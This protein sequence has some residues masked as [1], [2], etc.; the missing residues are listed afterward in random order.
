MRLLLFTFLLSALSFSQDR[1]GISY[2]ALI[3]NPNVE[4][5]P[6]QDNDHSPLTNTD[7]C[8]QFHI[9]NSSG[10]YEYSESQSVTTDA[11][12]MVNLVIGTGLPIGAI[13]WDAV[14]WSAEAKSLK[15]DLDITG[16]CTSF[17][18][19]S[20]QQ[21]TSVPF[22]LYSPSSNVPGPKGDPGD[23]GADGDSA[24]QVWLDE[25]NTGTEQ[26][27]LDA[28]KGTDGTPGA[29]GDSAYQVWLD[30]GNTGTEQEFLESLKG[31]DGSP[32][33]GTEGK[34]AYDIWIELGNT[35]TE[36]DF[37]D[38]LVGPQGE[39]GQDGAG[40]SG[41]G[42][43]NAINTNETSLNLYGSS[44]GYNRFKNFWNT[45]ESYSSNFYTTTSGNEINIY[46]YDLNKIGKSINIDNVIFPTGFNKFNLSSFGGVSAINSDGTT[47]VSGFRTNDDKSYYA[48]IELVNS[49]WVVKS[50]IERPSVN[51][52][53]FN[54]DL[55]K[56]ITV[57]S[58][59]NQYYL[60]SHEIDL[61]NSTLTLID[62]YN[63]PVTNTYQFY[64]NDDFNN[65]V[66]TGF[67]NSRLNMQLINISSLGIFSKK[68]DFSTPHSF[69]N[70]YD[71]Y[72]PQ[73][74]S[75]SMNSD[76]TVL[77]VIISCITKHGGLNSQST[78][79][80]MKI[81]SVETNTL[82]NKISKK[83][84]SNAYSSPFQSP[85][86][87]LNELG[88]RI[89]LGSSN[90]TFGVNNVL[91]NVY[92]IS[93]DELNIIGGSSFIP[94]PASDSNYTNTLRFYNPGSTNFQFSE[95]WRK[96]LVFLKDSYSI[97]IKKI[98]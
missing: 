88:N 62:Q 96:N 26:D 66:V 84:P 34:S 25:G 38:S 20:N 78:E 31:A 89:F 87:I 63:L 46:D 70:I 11:Y 61:T 44:F 21:L 47:Y 45:S 28:L 83:L 53:V 43:A 33:E 32:G 18:E 51:K 8:L 23:P 74:I 85:H 48:F 68:Y 86:L 49:D 94:K 79:H 54:D 13:T 9:I 64:L 92:D 15:V 82:V 75:L 65:L 39:P 56:L 98:Q 69:T 57:T 12:G 91:W 3:I 17:T 90:S 22:A 42:L 19:L 80:E 6:G 29:D 24:Y 58:D 30:A 73:L 41:N 1:N 7:I 52:T 93:N 16:A 2:Q 10:N 35:G 55:T 71:N 77:G 67:D 60:S 97:L 40:T 50:I 4:Q 14:D 81:Y 72:T 36:Q 76:G 95:N 37:I 59:T 5:L 27:F